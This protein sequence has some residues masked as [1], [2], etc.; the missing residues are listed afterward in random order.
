MID[1]RAFLATM[2]IV[3]ASASVEAQ[4][5]RKPPRIGWLTSSV[6]HTR[7]VEMFRAEGIPCI[8]FHSGYYD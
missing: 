8:Y 5:A 4:P 1:R 6:V 3:V 7:N 2:V